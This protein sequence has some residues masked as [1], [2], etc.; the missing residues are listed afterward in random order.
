MTIRQKYKD[1]LCFLFEQLPMFQRIGPAA[2]KKDLTNTLALMEALGEPHRKYP[3]IH[4]AGTN[5][6]G[7]VAHM[8]AAIGS[9]HGLKTGLYISPHYKDF[10]ERIKVDGQYVS[11]E[12]VVEFTDRYRHLFDTIKPSFFEITVA[13]AFDYFAR[14]KVDLAVIET[15]LG[16]RLDSTNVITPVLSVITNISYDHQQFLGDTLPLIA[17]EKAGIIKQGIPVV[18]GETQEESAPVFRVKAG[19]MAAPIEFAD[20]HFRLVWRNEDENFTVYDVFRDGKLYLPDLKTDLHGPYQQKNLATVLES[21]EA[22]KKTSALQVR[23]DRLRHAL[24]HVRELSGFM[25]RWQ[26]IGRSPDIL[27]DSAHNEGGLRPVMERLAALPYRRLHIVFGMVNDKAPD[28]VL[29]LL[30]KNACY[31]FARADI[32]RGLDAKT[33]KDHAGRSGLKGRAYSSVRNALKAAKRAAGP[34]DLVF[35]GGSIFVVAEVV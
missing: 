29:G 13:M 8:L 4:I 20:A 32:P 19:Q 31:Y 3:C 14:E 17:G 2:F 26:M 12:Y 35:V 30:P 5:G 21:V 23:Q 15:G 34:E 6:K 24:A 28:A 10:R 16:G 22:L 18:I 11:R 9:A 1:T 7:S 25:G 33:L 27:V